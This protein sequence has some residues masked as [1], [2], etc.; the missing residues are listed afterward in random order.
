MFTT[1][2]AGM[3][4]CIYAM[5][6]AGNLVWPLAASGIFWVHSWEIALLT[7]RHAGTSTTTSAA[8]AAPTTSVCPCENV[9]TQ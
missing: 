3:E 2:F 6:T 8:V 7:S 5:Q 4:C 1:V 9:K